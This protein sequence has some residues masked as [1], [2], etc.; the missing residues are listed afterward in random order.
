MAVSTKLKAG[1]GVFAVFGLGIF[2]GAFALLVVIVRVVPLS[3]GWSTEESRQFL[4]NHFARALDL[5]SEQREQFHPILGEALDRRWELRR[6]YLLDS[7]KLIEEE[8]YPRIEAILTDEQRVKAREMLER[9][10]RDQKFKLEP[11][12]RGN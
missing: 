6:G 1:C 2:L 4:E 9:W 5:S 3:E 8:Y 7:R 11:P 12:P 10:N